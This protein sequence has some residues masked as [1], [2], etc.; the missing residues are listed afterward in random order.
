MVAVSSR[1][2]RRLKIA[3]WFAGGALLLVALFLGVMAVLILNAPKLPKELEHPPAE[4]LATLKNYGPQAKSGRMAPG[5]VPAQLPLPKRAA[6]VPASFESYDQ[7]LFARSGGNPAEQQ[8]IDLYLELHRHWQEACRD[9]DQYARAFCDGSWWFPAQPLKPE[10]IAWL[11][12]HGELGEKARR[13]V[14][15]PALPQPSLEE[16]MA[17]LAARPT[18]ADHI[19]FRAWHEAEL[20]PFHSSTIRPRTL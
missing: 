6:T 5:A 4:V 15:I 13:L 10:Q 20:H 17:W 1:S 18:M 11:H 12:A 14:T 8:A 7:F 2:L 19:D 3:L 9:D 16:Q